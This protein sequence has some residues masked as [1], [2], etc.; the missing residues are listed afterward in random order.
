[1]SFPKI[2]FGIIVLNGE[3]FLRYNLQALYPYAHQIIVV[4]GACQT[5]VAISTPDGHSL[6]DTREMLSQFKAESDPQDKL[7]IVQA[8]DDGKPDGF[9]QEK[10]EMS[11]A[12]ARRA[13]GDW[14]WQVDYDEFYLEADLQRLGAFLAQNPQAK[15]V[16]LPFIQF[17]G[18]FH[19]IEGGRL[20]DYDY[21][22]IDRI[23]RWKPGY[24]YTHHRP[25]TVVDEHGVNLRT[26]PGWV[27]YR[28]IKHMGIAMRHYTYIL[29]K[30]AHQKVGYYAT[31]SWTDDFRNENQWLQDGFLK[32][33]D[34]YH[35]GEYGSRKYEWLERYDG[36]HPRAI[37]DLLDD[38]QS[39]KV[40]TPLRPTQD[41]D[42][43]LA[44]PSYRLGKMWRRFELF[45]TWHTV[46][47][48]RVVLH[49]IGA[50]LLGESGL[51][52]L[53]QTLRSLRSGNKGDIS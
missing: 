48:H 40:D 47:Q 22:Y 19:S 49:K 28:E 11:Q 30:Q 35:I 52:R 20:M 12:Y 25:P 42:D 50:R 27:D 31:A 8:E 33:K 45:V 3:P 4:E 23:F 43:L 26:Q 5:A 14:L 41:I 10:D 29:P 1:L 36:P 39:G 38:I 15:G 51:N 18:S 21:R 9:W 6:D 46:I 2:T 44:S 13:S 16:S 32:I 53:V 7:V 24:R 34:P 17:W 37:Q